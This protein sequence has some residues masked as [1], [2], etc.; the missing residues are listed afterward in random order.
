MTKKYKHTMT[1][2]VG[3]VIAERGETVWVDTGNGPYTSDLKYWEEFIP[4][5]EIGDVW[6]SAMGTEYRVVGVDAKRGVYHIV[7]ADKFHHGDYLVPAFQE[8]SE[9]VTI[10]T[11]RFPEKYLSFKE[12]P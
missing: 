1:G 3:E 6:T 10:H 4:N 11:R 9:N 12:R 8:D 2:K 7:Q 5:P